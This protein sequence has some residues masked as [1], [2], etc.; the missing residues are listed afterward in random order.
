MECTII[1]TA[2]GRVIE[3]TTGYFAIKTRIKTEAWIEIERTD[4]KMESI[5]SGTITGYAQA[6]AATKRKV[7]FA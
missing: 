4:G 3:A 1:T 2:Q 7:G 5:A 6:T